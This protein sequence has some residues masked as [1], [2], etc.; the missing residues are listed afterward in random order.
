MTGE[1]D[2]VVLAIG[3]TVP[4][5]LPI[6]GSAADTRRHALP[7]TRTNSSASTHRAPTHVRTSLARQD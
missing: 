5:N 4:N 3:S 6:P 1:F 7:R 2:A